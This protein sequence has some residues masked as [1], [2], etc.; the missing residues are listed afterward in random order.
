MWLAS[1]ITAP[2]KP[3]SVFSRPL[4]SSGA[5][6]AGRMSASARLGVELLL[7]VRQRDVAGHDHLDAVGDVRP[8]DLAEAGLPLL[9]LQ[10]VDAEHQVLV[11]LLDPV[12]GPVLDA[13]E[14]AGLA[15]ALDERDRVLDD[16]GGVGAVGAGVDDGVAPVEQDVDAGVEV[17]VGADGPHLPPGHVAG[18]VGDLGRP[19]R[20]GLGAGGDVGAVAHR[21]VAAGVAVGCDQQRD[22]GRGLQ[23]VEQALHLLRRAAVVAGD[24]D[25][26]LLDDL[27]S[28]V[29]IAGE[30]VGAEEEQVG[31][32]L[33]DLLVQRHRGQGV[34]H[35]GELVGVEVVRRGGEV[36]E[37]GHGASFFT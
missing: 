31:E 27:L 28:G 33:A 23:P 30:A 17:E 9:G 11:A 16:V 1:V 10:V 15:L 5:S 26:E 37:R 19:G 14:D 4:I 2:L 22:P 29:R 35:P 32:Q 8:V 13:A 6:V 18:V 34:L 3:R 36:Y 25:V 24:A 12:P 21:A 20:L 7:V